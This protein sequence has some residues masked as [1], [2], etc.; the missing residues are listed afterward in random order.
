MGLEHSTP[1]WRAETSRGEGGIGQIWP[2]HHS[3]RVHPPGGLE[4][5]T[6]LVRGSP[7]A[8]ASIVLAFLALA[9]GL[10][11]ALWNVHESRLEAAKARAVKDFLLSILGQGGIGRADGQTSGSITLE[12]V[13]DSGADRVRRE[14]KGRPDVRNDVLSELAELQGRLDAQPKAEALYRELL[15]ALEAEHGPRSLDAADARVRLARSVRD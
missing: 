8:V 10:G 15:T 5:V 2:E 13:L 7:L 9:G 12:Q 4:R 6:R 11:G 14:L 3:A 1:G